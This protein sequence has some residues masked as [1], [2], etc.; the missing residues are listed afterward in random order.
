MKK[1]V[2][3]SM[4]ITINA[5]ITTNPGPHGGDHGVTLDVT[6]NDESKPPFLDI[7]DQDETNWIERHP[8]TQA[9]RWR[10]SGNAAG[11]TFNPIDDPKAPGFEWVGTPPPKEVFS[12]IRRSR[13]GREILVDDLNDGETTVGIWYYRLNAMIEGMPVQSHKETFPPSGVT[14]NASIKNK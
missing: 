12:H 1:K 9:V 2:K 11:G 8:D 13:N 5:V 10:L 6:L 7:D 4:D 14:T 3:I